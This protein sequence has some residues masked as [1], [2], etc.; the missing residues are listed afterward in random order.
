MAHFAKIDNL[1]IVV[2]ITVG[3]EEDNGKELE[4]C[5]RTGDTYRQTSYNTRGG[6]HYKPNSHEPSED[7]SKAFRKNFAGIGYTFDKDRDAFIP[8]KPFASWTLNEDTCL[9]EPNTPRPD[10]GKV[11]NWNEET[12]SW[13][14]VIR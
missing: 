10:D 13:D 11:Y 5:A 9:W 8:P 1:E 6:I 12:K 14:E 2:F 3:R 4:L 7:Q